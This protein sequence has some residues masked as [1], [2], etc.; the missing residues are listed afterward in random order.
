[1]PATSVAQKR[2]DH[3]NGRYCVK[4]QSK[5][6]SKGAVSL[7]KGKDQGVPKNSI[8][9]PYAD[10]CRK[11]NREKFPDGCDWKHPK[12]HYDNYKP[13]GGG[14][15]PGKKRNGKQK[16]IASGARGGRR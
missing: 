11:L 3:I 7:S 14:Q 15:P 12:A 6:Q 4:G 5:G 10:K 1:M 13:P 9:C 2:A 8:D 16:G